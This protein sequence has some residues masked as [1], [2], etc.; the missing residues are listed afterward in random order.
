MG[1]PRREDR[2]MSS[3]VKQRLDEH[4]DEIANTLRL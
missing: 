1:G 4:W 2:P 3:A